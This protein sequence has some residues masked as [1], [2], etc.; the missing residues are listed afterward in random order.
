MRGDREVNRKPMDM[1]FVRTADGKL[2]RA[3][4]GRDIKDVW[5]DLN[6]IKLKEAIEK[7]EKK[8]ARKERRRGLFGAVK[9]SEKPRAGDENAKTV[10]IKI[11][12][13]EIS[14]SGFFKRVGTRLRNLPFSRKQYGAAIG[15]VVFLVLL[16][17]SFSLYGNG[18]SSGDKKGKKEVAGAEVSAPPYPTV[19]P[20]DKTIEDLGGWSRVSPPDK[21]PVYAFNDR[22][23]DV[24]ITVSEQPLPKSFQED[25]AGQ[26]AKLAE[27]FAANDKITAGDSQAFLGTSAQGPQSVILTKNDL[28]I[29][30]KSASKLTNSQWENYLATLQ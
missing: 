29:L 19:V 14:L 5:A 15:I 6:R 16:I 22:I 18:S 25:A 23:G 2:R 12:F 24:A 28:L 10:E 27:E 8:R 17:A 13:P 20:I 26:I 1:G 7:D 11:N 30:V 9:A 4:E 3:D 21:D